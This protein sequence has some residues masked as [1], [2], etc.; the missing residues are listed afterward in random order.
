VVPLSRCRTRDRGRG[1]GPLHQ[2]QDE[3][4]RRHHSVGPGGGR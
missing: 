1:R 4:P 2:V 3:R